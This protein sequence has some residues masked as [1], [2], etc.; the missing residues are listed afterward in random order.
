MT[1][2]HL[3]ALAG[4]QAC[5]LDCVIS[6]AGQ[7]KGCDQRK[8]GTGQILTGLIKLWAEQV[9]P[10]MYEDWWVDVERCGWRCVF[11]RAAVAR[12]I[13][14]VQDWRRTVWRRDRLHLGRR[15]WRWWSVERE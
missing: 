2:Q 13:K 11:I 8:G 9:M 6:T 3:Q 7:Q 5:H 4:A 15:L 14:G 12:L 1:H 10:G